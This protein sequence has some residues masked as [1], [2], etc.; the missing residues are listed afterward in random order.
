[1]HVSSSPC[2]VCDNPPIT[3]H[4]LDLHLQTHISQ[5]QNWY[6]EYE[7]EQK[8]A[9]YNTNNDSILLNILEVNKRGGRDKTLLAL[10]ICS[11]SYI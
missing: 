11:Q 1:M 9:I 2:N 4:N 5:T 8:E 6:T 3:S 7:G 10:Q